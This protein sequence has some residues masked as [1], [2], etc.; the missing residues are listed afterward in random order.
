M[1]TFTPNILGN[2]QLALAKA[3]IY[4]CPAATYALIKTITLV[5]TSASRTVNIYV[6]KS[7][8][9]SRRIIAKDTPID[10]VLERHIQANLTLG[11]GDVIEGD[12]SAATEIDYCIFGVEQT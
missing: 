2:G 12:A 10:L 8:G 6:K 1:P 7:G 4:T 5:A 11:A 3:T 9:T